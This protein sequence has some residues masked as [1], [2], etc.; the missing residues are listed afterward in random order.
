MRVYCLVQSSKFFNH[1][2]L[3]FILSYPVSLICMSTLESLSR[4]TNN[5][6]PN[7]LL[8]CQNIAIW[9]KVCSYRTGQV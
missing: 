6:N 1:E 9:L 4:A 7:I 5:G 8:R 3:Y 2:F